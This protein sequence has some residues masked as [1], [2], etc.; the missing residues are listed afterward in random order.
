MGYSANVKSTSIVRWPIL[1]LA[2]LM[3][4]GSYYCFDIPAA[5]NQQLDDYF[6]QQDDYATNF[7]LLYS[8]YAIPNVILPF[9]G[10][11][12][13]DRWSFL[14]S[15]LVWIM[16]TYAFAIS[17]LACDGACSSSLHLLRLGNFFSVLVF[18]S[19]LGRWSCWDEPSLALEGRA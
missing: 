4:V 14:V 19:N 7:S 17:D 11:Y 10:G 9:F 5:L 2:C 12:F 8:L 1:V 18:L 13:V 6:G 15:S 3:L 16:F